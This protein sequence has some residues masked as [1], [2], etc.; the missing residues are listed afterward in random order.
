METISFPVPEIQFS[1]LMPLLMVVGAALLVLLVELFFPRVPHTALSGLGVLGL[2]ASAYFLML[3]W[4]NDIATFADM[5]RSDNLSV[6]FSL[7]IVGATA[8]TML[9]SEDYLQAR[10]IRLGEF[11]PLL[12]F[13]TAGALIM[14]SSTDLIVIFLGLE[15]LSL[16][17]YVLCGLARTEL[18][19]EESALKYFLLGAFASAFLLY[20][21][22][23][24]YG[25]V[26]NVD[27]TYIASA[28]NNAQASNNPVTPAL[29][30]AGAALMIVGLGFKAALV[31]FH[32]WTPDVYQGAPT[33]V[34]AYM[35]AV[36]K[37]A[38]FAVLARLIGSMMPLQEVWGPVLWWLSALS[39]TIGNLVAMVQRD[40]KRMLAYSSI[41]HAGYLV[42]GIVSANAAGVAAMVFYLVVYSLMT[43]GAFGVLSLMS[44]A[45]DNTSISALQGL[46]KRH[47]FLAI[48]M[49][50]LLFSLAGVPPTAG[51][52]GKWYLF[53][54]A[55][56]ANQ[57]A[58]AVILAVNSV[59]GAYYYLR[60]TLTLY[61]DAP[62][63]EQLAL[64]APAGMV[65]CLLICVVGLIGLG[66]MP[67][68]IAD[69]SREAAQVMESWLTAMKP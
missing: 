24:V 30:I 29:L 56:Q 69:W 19:S 44:R 45:G 10:G 52:W 36:S 34:T 60:L 4:R 9:F 55:V 66:L 58:L 51:F 5:L 1:A 27:M 47:P 68:P 20:G 48:V 38:A 31:P 25:A 53:L 50:V 35:A 39:M 40:A 3:L 41:A 64:R 26:G 57:I 28:W 65:A 33:V 11:Y 17:L 59:I 12:L 43:I 42:I 37:V 18:R 67:T 2:G 6:M 62:G 8:L 14:V 32:M 13:A 61:A 15:V 21:I 63:E 22:A 49:A 7:I 16:S 54:G 23:L 46:W